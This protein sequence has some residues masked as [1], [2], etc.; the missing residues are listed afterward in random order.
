VT[1]AVMEH[2]TRTSRPSY[3]GPSIGFSAQRVAL[4]TQARGNPNPRSSQMTARFRESKPALISDDRALPRR[5]QPLSLPTG[6]PSPRLARH[7][8]TSRVPSPARQLRWL[9]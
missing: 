1:F 8:A 4:R 7:R 2:M 9:D 5:H 6:L 3:C